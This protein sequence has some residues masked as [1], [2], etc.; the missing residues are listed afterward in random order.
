MPVLVARKAGRVVGY[1]VSSSKAAQG[2]RAD[3]PGHAA[4][5][6]G[7]AGRL[8]LRPD[9]RCRERAR[10]GPAGRIDVGTA[11]AAARPAKASPSSAAT[12]RR[13]MRAHAKIGMRE[14]AEFIHDDAPSSWLSYPA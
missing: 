8:P 1:L 3:R 7:R 13:S 10:A 2:A 12:T 5:L 14:V 4:G 11:R 6:S 9:L